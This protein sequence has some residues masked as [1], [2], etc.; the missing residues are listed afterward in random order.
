MSNINISIRGPKGSLPSRL[1]KEDVWGKFI[2]EAGITFH[3]GMIVARGVAEESEIGIRK[4]YPYDVPFECPVWGD[5]LP[6]KSVTVVC[7]ESLVEE[8]TYWLEF[9]HGGGC[10]SNM[11]EVGESQVALRGDYM[12]W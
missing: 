1:T 12:C 5:R 10:V 11:K 6:Y 9:V 3:R 4:K 8:V 7:H 2:P